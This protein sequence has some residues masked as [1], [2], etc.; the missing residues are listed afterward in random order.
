LFIMYNKL[1]RYN[2]IIIAIKYNRNEN[3]TLRY[4]RY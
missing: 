2:I 1:L 3:T 4:T